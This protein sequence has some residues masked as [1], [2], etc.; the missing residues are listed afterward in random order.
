MVVIAIIGILSAV[1]LPAM[2][3]AQE[4]AKSSA[5]KQSAVQAGKR[6]S[7]ELIGEGTAADG[8]SSTATGDVTHTGT[9]CANDAAFAYAGGGDTWTVTLVSG[10]PLAPAK[11]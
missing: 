9:T 5:A 11:S 1:A 2:T 7:F 3:N 6:C 8:N 10:I 4:R